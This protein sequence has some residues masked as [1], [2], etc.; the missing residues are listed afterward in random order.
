MPIDA[1]VS[2]EKAGHFCPAPKIL[3]GGVGAACREEG[4][5]FAHFGLLRPGEVATVTTRR[6]AA[7]R[8]ALARLAG[9]AFGFDRLLG[10]GGLGRWLGGSGLGLG[11]NR[12][13]LLALAFRAEA[14]AVALAV[15]A[16]AARRALAILALFALLLAGLVALA[17]L[18]AFALRKLLLLLL[19]RLRRGEAGIHVRHIVVEVIVLLALR[20]LAALGLL[21]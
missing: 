8:T 21:G 13:R 16:V 9:F 10:G 12:S 7:A 14:L 6:T 18:L 1:G 19:L 4:R 17:L 2:K 15:A 3:F 20:P 11:G 5:Q